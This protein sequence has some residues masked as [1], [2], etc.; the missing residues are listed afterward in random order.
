MEINYVQYKVIIW[1]FTQCLE[2][3]NTIKI[4]KNLHILSQ[5]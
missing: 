4:V 3:N 5:I 2:D 1:K